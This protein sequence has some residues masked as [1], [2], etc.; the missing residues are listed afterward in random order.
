[1]ARVD[2][3]CRMGGSRAG[4][5]ANTGIAP[6]ARESLILNL[7]DPQDRRAWEEFV[8]LYRPVVYRVARSL[9]RA[10]AR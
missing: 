1:M 9:A 8:E 5:L 6:P 4:S 10:A 3:E 2:T 7:R